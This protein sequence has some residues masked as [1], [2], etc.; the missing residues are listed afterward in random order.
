[1]T[2]KRDRKSGGGRAWGQSSAQASKHR[3]GPEL[4]T[5]LTKTGR[6]RQA[7]GEVRA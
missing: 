6:G 7:R 2:V 5:Q 3:A 4:K 1:M